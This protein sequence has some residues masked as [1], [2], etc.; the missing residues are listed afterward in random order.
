MVGDDRRTA[1]GRERGKR[2][3]ASLATLTPRRATVSRQ[4][5]EGSTREGSWP[6]GSPYSQQSYPA[7]RLSAHIVGVP[8]RP[9][10]RIIVPSRQEVTARLLPRRKSEGGRHAEPEADAELTG[11]AGPPGA[12]RRRKAHPLGARVGGGPP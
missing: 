1:L 6:G 9:R 5:R 8:S 4:S 3:K 7:L 12:I 2:Q 10:L 11:P